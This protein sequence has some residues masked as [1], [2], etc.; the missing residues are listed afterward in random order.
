MADT[1]NETSLSRVP[2]LSLSC[3]TNNRHSYPRGKIAF[4][5]PLHLFLTGL[6]HVLKVK[7]L[8][9]LGQGERGENSLHD[10]QR[11]VRC[12]AKCIK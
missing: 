11:A 2:S 7:G 5:P 6:A 10:I 8:F 9:C 3:T 12:C 4:S 1:N